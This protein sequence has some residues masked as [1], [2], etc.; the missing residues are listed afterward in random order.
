MSCLSLLLRQLLYFSVFPIFR[1]L[2]WFYKPSKNC[3][4]QN[5]S[6]C[7]QTG[8]SFVRNC[9]KII[10]LLYSLLSWLYKYYFCHI[11]HGLLL[12]T[13]VEFNQSDFQ[14]Q[15]PFLSPS[16]Q[17][18]T[19]SLYFFLPIFLQY[20]LQNTLID[21]MLLN[22]CGKTYSDWMGISYGRHW[23]FELIC[24][25]TFNNITNLFLSHF[26]SKD[27]LFTFRTLLKILVCAEICTNHCDVLIQSS[28]QTLL[29]GNTTVPV[30][31]WGDFYFN[32]SAN[33]F[34][35]YIMFIW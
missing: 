19:H 20:G 10:I 15:W 13:H 6:H 23:S 1:Q 3:Q 26:I 7:L 11:C 32:P 17:S 31:F 34:W 2:E 16:F 9:G 21:F 33:C 12:G 25:S 18:T 14:S 29:N 8:L 24:L 35:Y 28:E 22:V 27:F 5:F 4:Y 30:I